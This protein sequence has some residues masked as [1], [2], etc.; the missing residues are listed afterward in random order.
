MKYP[1]YGKNIYISLA[2]G[3]STLLFFNQLL[4]VACTQNKLLMKASLKLLKGGDSENHALSNLR[5]Y[6]VLF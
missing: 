2:T 1:Y 3:I 6:Q 4:E 5:N